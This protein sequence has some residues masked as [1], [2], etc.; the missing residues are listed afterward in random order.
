[1]I[2]TGMSREHGSGDERQRPGHVRDVAHERDVA[3]ERGEQPGDRGPGEHGDDESEW[4]EPRALERYDQHDGHDADRERGDV[5]LPEVEDEIERPCQPAAAAGLVAGEVVQLAEH[6]VDADRRDEPGHH[7]VGHEAEERSEPEQAGGDHDEA[8]QDRQRVQRPRRVVTRGEV[9]VGD[10]D[11]H[12]AGSL[13]RHHRGTREQCAARQTEHVAVE[14]GHRVHAGEQSGGQ[15]VRHALDTEHEAGHGVVFDRLL[16]EQRAGVEDRELHAGLGTPA[17]NCG[18]R[19][20]TCTAANLL[21]RSRIH[22]VGVICTR[23][24]P[25]LDA[26]RPGSTPHN[27]DIE[28]GR[29][30]SIRN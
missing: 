29:V 6:D 5:D 30:R 1:M 12:G 9:D 16:R 28:P 2:S 22:H 21:R 11:R 10:D 8:G 19:T 24:A 18:R 7:R 14:P 4:T 17:G 13:N 25:V 20:R 15:P 27:G 23:G 3:V 26:R